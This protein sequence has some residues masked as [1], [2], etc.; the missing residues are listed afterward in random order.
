MKLQSSS[1]RGNTALFGM[2]TSD[3]VNAP[4]QKNRALGTSSAVLLIHDRFS[5]VAMNSFW[6]FTSAHLLH[7][8]QFA[9]I[10]QTIACSCAPPRLFSSPS[11]SSFISPFLLSPT[12]LRNKSAADV[13]SPFDET[14]L[15]SL[16]SVVIRLSHFDR[17]S[18]ALRI[19]QVCVRLMLFNF[20][21]F[22][23]LFLSF[24]LKVLESCCR[25]YSLPTH[26][27]RLLLLE[28]SLYLKASPTVLFPALTPL[29]RCLA[30]ASR[31]SLPLY[32]SLALVRIASIHLRLGNAK[33]AAVTLR[34]AMPR[35]MDNASPGECGRA[36]LLLAKC[37]L[38][39]LHSASRQ[40]PAPV[41]VAVLTQVLSIDFFVCLCSFRLLIDSSCF[42]V[43]NALEA[44]HRHLSQSFGEQGSADAQVEVNYLKSRVAASFP[45]SSSV[46]KQR[47]EISS[48]FIHSLNAR[49]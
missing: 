27:A 30:L 15:E 5:S 34:G 18:E 38:G 35:L 23:F 6:A 43:L 41:R 32:H 12:F 46:M 40:V 42:K 24:W 39:Q 37:Q 33:L 13:M 19:T 10:F 36:M 17:L 3:L 16:I 49:Q 22:N 21:K 47:D 29:I 2:D 48:L 14:F 25:E 8:E 4:P 31:F 9:K 20:Q 44:A 45:L 26:A 1:S 7:R 11:Q 28:S